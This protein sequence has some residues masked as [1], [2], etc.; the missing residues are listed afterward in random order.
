MNTIT[1]RNVTTINERTGAVTFG[2][3]G[4]GSTDRSDLASADVQRVNAL[5][6]RLS[7]KYKPAE[8]KKVVKPKAPMIVRSKTN[9]NKRFFLGV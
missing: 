9:D 6:A 2:L 5:L 7:N 8:A 1:M 3:I 4:G